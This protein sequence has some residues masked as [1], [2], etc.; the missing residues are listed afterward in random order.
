MTGTFLLLPNIEAGCVGICAILYF[1]P[2][3]VGRSG[4]PCITLQNFSIDMWM[5]IM[6][7]T[8]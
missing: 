3:V 8:I 1:R 5:N 2:S 6:G 4:A 7:K